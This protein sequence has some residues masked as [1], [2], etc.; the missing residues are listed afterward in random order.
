[1]RNVTRWSERASGETSVSFGVR[2]GCATWALA[3]V[4]KIVARKSKT[5]TL[6]RSLFSII[7]R[8][9]FEAE[10][11]IRRIK[12]TWQSPRPRAGRSPFESHQR[13]WEFQACLYIS[14][15]QIS[16][17][18]V[19]R[20]TA[21]VKTRLGQASVAG[22]LQVASHVNLLLPQRRSHRGQ[23]LQYMLMV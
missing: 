5:T 4:E 21:N 23:V 11:D 19:A 10:R 2:A 20:V 1:M 3:K 18:L 13:T 8:S 15:W 9:P 17:A 16:T 12:W 6:C 22:K 14:A 7:T